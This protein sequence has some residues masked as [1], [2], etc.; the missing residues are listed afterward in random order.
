M[1]SG[2]LTAIIQVGR[3]GVAGYAD[4]LYL[5]DMYTTYSTSAAAC[6][7]EFDARVGAYKQTVA[8][9]HV[10]D[11]SRHLRAD[12]ESAMPAVYLALFYQYI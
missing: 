12:Y 3:D 7:L 4:H 10:V 9:G 11:A 5:G 1:L 8:H 2:C 6:R